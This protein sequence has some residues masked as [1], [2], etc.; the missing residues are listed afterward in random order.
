M[1]VHGLVVPAAP[2]EKVRVTL[3]PTDS[4][5]DEIRVAPAPV[6]RQSEI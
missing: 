2:D 4:A 3:D 6:N 5:K 1:S